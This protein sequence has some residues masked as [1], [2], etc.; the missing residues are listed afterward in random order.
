VV[1]RKYEHDK[2]VVESVLFE[3]DNVLYDSTGE[4][5]FDPLDDDF[6]VER[7]KEDIRNNLSQA[8]AVPTY[9]LK[10]SFVRL[11]DEMEMVLAPYLMNI[12][13]LAQ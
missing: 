3:G 4:Q 7:T 5:Y 13:R 10:V 2:I 9:H 1:C 6:L 12:K 8:S 11:P